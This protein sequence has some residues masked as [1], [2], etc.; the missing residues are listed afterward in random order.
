MISEAVIKN[1]SQIHPLSNG[2]I[3]RLSEATKQINLKAKTILLEQGKICKEVFFIEKGFAHAFYHKIGQEI[4]SWFMG[5]GDV[6]VSVHSFYEQRPSYESIRLLEDSLLTSLRYDDLQIIYKEFPEF[7]FIGRILTEK[8]YI[9]SEERTFSLRLQTS[10]ER[11]KTLLKAHPE[12]FNRASL[13]Y[14]ASYL[15]M[16]PETLSRL[17]AKVK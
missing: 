8:Y 6:I 16:T 13:K 9:L 3:Q 12:I 17:R 5:E 2:L 10:E 4:T 11:Y 14:I 7:N 15:G 1:L